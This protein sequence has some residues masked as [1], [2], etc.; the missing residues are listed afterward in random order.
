[1]A[2]D[3]HERPTPLYPHDEFCLDCHPELRV[4]RCA[5]DD[6]TEEDFGV[7]KIAGLVLIGV[8]GGAF[9]REIVS[10]FRPWF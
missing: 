1:M 8:V 9:W 6:D 2:A 3:P 4:E 10:L 7:G 5:Y